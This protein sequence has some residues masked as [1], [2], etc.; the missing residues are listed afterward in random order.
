MEAPRQQASV[1]YRAILCIPIVCAFLFSPVTVYALIYWGRP[2]LPSI[3]QQIA[4]M[5]TEELIKVDNECMG[6]FAEAFGPSAT[7]EG[8]MHEAISAFCSCNSNT[9][10]VVRLKAEQF[11]QHRLDEEG[12][13]L[14]EITTLQVLP[15]DEI[16]ENRPRGSP[17]GT[18]LSD[19]LTQRYSAILRNLE[20]EKS[21]YYRQT[22]GEAVNRTC[23]PILA[24]WSGSYSLKVQ[25]YLRVHRNLPPSSPPALKRL[26]DHR[27][28]VTHLITP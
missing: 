13:I 20:E 16:Y 19:K 8:P 22:Y 17:V 4:E 28:Q 14:Q 21:E 1:T 26:L 18:K 10:I 7:E 27:R 24:P 12:K 25:D 11:F 5:P 15:R 3:A 23:V 6:E 2:L 9:A